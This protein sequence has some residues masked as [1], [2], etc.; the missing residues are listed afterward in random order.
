MK[1]TKCWYI[2]DLGI[3]GRATQTETGEYQNPKIYNQEKKRWYPDKENVLLERINRHKEKLDKLVV[4]QKLHELEQIDNIALRFAEDAFRGMVDE[5]GVPVIEHSIAVA[6]KMKSPETRAAAYLHDIV[7]D[8]KVTNED[9]RRAFGCRMAEIISLLTHNAED[10]YVDDY[11]WY[12]ADDSVASEVKLAD[13]IH[14]LERDYAH[15]EK[16]NAKRIRKHEG[17]VLYLLWYWLEM[18]DE[19]VADRLSEIVYSSTDEIKDFVFGH[20]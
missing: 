2:K 8:T 20:L 1:K 17:G 19:L 4:G 11:L 14:N 18:G 15:P 16:D 12:I 5:D 10:D 6:S 3:L 9:I 7:E 13:L